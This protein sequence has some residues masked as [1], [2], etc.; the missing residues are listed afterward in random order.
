MKGATVAPFILDSLVPYPTLS[1]RLSRHKE[2]GRLNPTPD[3][4]PELPTRRSLKAAR[5]K[6]KRLDLVVY[7]AIITVLAIPATYILTS[8][9]F[10]QDIAR[11]PEPTRVPFEQPTVA[12]TTVPDV[13]IASGPITGLEFDSV[14]FNSANLVLPSWQTE[15]II[16]WTEQDNIANNGKLTPPNPDSSSIVWDSTVPGGGEVGTD[17]QTSATIVGHTSPYRKAGE[18]LGVFQPLM[19]VE[20]GDPATVVNAHGRLCYTVA[21]VDETIRKDSII[22]TNGNG[23]I[24]KGDMYEIDAKYRYADPVPGT[25]YVITCSRLNDGNNGPTT[26]YRVLVLKINQG[27]IN[28]GS[29]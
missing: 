23:V 5:R 3:A 13:D 10:R 17:V 1:L 16:R 18:P 4:V 12:P 22:D 26:H 2:G 20:V 14:G 15:P 27:A 25:I 11:A 19:K 29:C 8:P 24:D 6:K 7:L 21:A 28:A 9:S